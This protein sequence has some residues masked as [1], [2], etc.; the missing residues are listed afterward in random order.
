MYRIRRAVQLSLS[1]KI[2]P[3]EEWTKM[4]DVSFNPA[5]YFIHRVPCDPCDPY[6]FVQWRGPIASFTQAAADVSGTGQALYLAH[7]RADQGRPEGEGG[8]RHDGG[9]PQALRGIL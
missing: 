1:N 2:L 3:K 7:Y 6:E 9:P 4:E 5:D 8:S